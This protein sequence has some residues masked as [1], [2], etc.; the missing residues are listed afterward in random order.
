MEALFFAKGVKEEE[1]LGPASVV[2]ALEALESFVGNWRGQG[3][4][5]I[6][7]ADVVM[8]GAVALERQCAGGGDGEGEG[9]AGSGGSVSGAS[10]RD[11]VLAVF[12]PEKL[13][14]VREAISAP[15]SEHWIYAR[16]AL[17]ACLGTLLAAAE[18]PDRPPSPTH[19][20]LT[21]Q[22][23]SKQGR[24]REVNVYRISYPYGS[25]RLFLLVSVRSVGR[26]W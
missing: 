4:G 7:A 2:A 20:P 1:G 22:K 16:E 10:A 8:L 5:V 25:S 12:T 17:S 18:P 9:G 26:R 24:S 19:K 23:Q 3:E 14:Q 6:E 15:Y 13:S 11:A 21:P